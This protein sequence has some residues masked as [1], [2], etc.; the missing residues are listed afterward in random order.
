MNPNTP[1]FGE[2]KS[3]SRI[4]TLVIIA[5]LVLFCMESIAVAIIFGI[6][7]KEFS[8]ISMSVVIILV[9]IVSA[10]LYRWHSEGDLDPKFKYLLILSALLTFVTCI[11]CNIFVFTPPP[12]LPVLPDV[13]G[14]QGFFNPATNSCLTGNINPC[15]TSPDFCFS[16]RTR[17]CR[18][19]TA[20]C[21]WPTVPPQD[22]LFE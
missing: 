19:C 17:T 9:G 4:A 1:L 14:C 6:I 18:N 5:V 22:W 15:M 7:K 10:L 16:M 3:S 13:W 21:T 12:K 20:H 2:E 8:H 11:T